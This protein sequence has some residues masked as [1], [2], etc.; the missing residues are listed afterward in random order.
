MQALDNFE[1]EL[2]KAFSDMRADL[3]RHMRIFGRL[4]EDLKTVK[5]FEKVKEPD[6]RIKEEADYNRGF[7]HGY[8][9]GMR[10]AQKQAEQARKG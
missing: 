5:E 3:E 4:E 10:D 7:Y 6:S 9:Q 8:T 1:N 2:K